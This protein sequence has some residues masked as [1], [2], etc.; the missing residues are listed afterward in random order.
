MSLSPEDVEI[1][2]HTY[3]LCLPECRLMRPKPIA[4]VPFWYLQILEKVERVLGY[5][6]GRNCAP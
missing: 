3:I 2:Q 1:V 4:I 6:T 5:L